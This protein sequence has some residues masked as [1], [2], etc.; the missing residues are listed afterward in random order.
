MKTEKRHMFQTEASVSMQRPLLP[1][2]SLSQPLSLGAD[3]LLQQ[4]L[5]QLFA[6]RILR[7]KVLRTLIELSLV[8]SSTVFITL[9]PTKC[10]VPCKKYTNFDRFQLK[11]SNF[12]SVLW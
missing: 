6:L 11:L 8:V 4:R 5:Q 2:F 1:T 12:E 3:F 10:T 9:M 7:E